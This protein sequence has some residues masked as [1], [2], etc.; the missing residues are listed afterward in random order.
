M[1][2]PFIN[3]DINNNIT[4]NNNNKRAYVTIDDYNNRT[5][6]N[7]NMKY[8]I[9]IMLLYILESVSVIL[10]CADTEDT[11]G[12]NNS[13]FTINY[14]LIM[15]GIYNMIGYTLIHQNNYKKYNTKLLF[16]FYDSIKL[17]FI[18]LGFII[19]FKFNSEYNNF[20]LP[21]SI[22][23][24]LICCIYLKYSIIITYKLNTIGL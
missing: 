16:I 11:I 13:N 4:N 15:L 19:I 20:I 18:L 1:L 6:D 3:N 22:F 17:I 21:Y 8:S 12:M 14:I 5:S 10:G 23:Y 2:N 9:I 7:V 24:L